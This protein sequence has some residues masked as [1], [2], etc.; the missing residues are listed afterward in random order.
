MKQINNNFDA[1]YYLTEEGKIYNSKTDNYIEANQVHSF[2]LKT[3][4]GKYKK[5]T[6][7][8]LYKIVFD[9]Y[10][11][12]DNIEDLEE[13][14]WKPIERTNNIYWISDKGRV[15]SYSNYEAIILKPS[16]VR[17]YERVDIYQEGSRCGKL[18]SRL[19][20]AAFLL[21]PAALDMQLHHKN[22]I[23]TDNRKEN[24]V[25]LTPAEHR[26]EH[27]RMKAAELAE[28]EQQEGEN[29]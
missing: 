19:V 10:Y 8:E 12:I 14:N 11:V 1:C 17:G 5:I 22:G 25:W 15:K 16:Y 27:K 2:R 4:E 29:K 18:I 20:A 7:R 21:P 24:L 23:K 6:L 9:K 28:L 26:A 3:I 13:E